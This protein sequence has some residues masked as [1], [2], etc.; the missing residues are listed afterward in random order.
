MSESDKNFAN[1]PMEKPK[2]DLLVQAFGRSPKEPFLM[3]TQPDKA[4]Q[5]LRNGA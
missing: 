2:T 3:R 1:P 4:Q 5:T